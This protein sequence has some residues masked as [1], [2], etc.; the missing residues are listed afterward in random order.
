MDPVLKSS[1]SGSCAAMVSAF[2][3]CP[4][5]VLRTRQ[6]TQNMKIKRKNILGTIYRENGI[7]GFF[8]GGGMRC[9]I[10]GFGG[11]I[12]FGALQKTRLLLEIERF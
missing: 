12:Y 4:L 11:I 5:D 2:L 10:M 6:M 7:A 1:I 8:R 9:G 3:S